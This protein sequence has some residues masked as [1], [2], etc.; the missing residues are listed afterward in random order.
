MDIYE[1][2]YTTRAMRRLKPDPIPV[3]VQARLMDAAVRAPT[4]GNMQDWKFLLLDDRDSLARLAPIYR[5]MLERLWSTTY[6]QAAVAAA[7]D[8]DA[9][10]SVAFRKMQRSANHLGEHF[11]QIPL[12]LFAFSKS[13]PTGASIIPAVWSAMLAARA[14]GIG[15]SFTSLLMFSPDEV[16]PILDIPKGW[17]MRASVAL[18]FATGRWGIAPRKPAHTVTY[19]NRW[20]EPAGFESPPLPDTPGRPVW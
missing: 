15:S 14:E 2:L 3:E 12:M 5:R 18:G 10:S 13:D 9:A 11:E 6:Q 7:A 20:G 4:G 16:L 1:A 19:R 17:E 8:P